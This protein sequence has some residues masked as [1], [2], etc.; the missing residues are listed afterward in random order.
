[1]FF[2]DRW[3]PQGLFGKRGPGSTRGL[4]ALPLDSST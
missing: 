1:L 4:P 3:S 2:G